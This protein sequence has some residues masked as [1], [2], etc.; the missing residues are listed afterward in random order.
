M[1]FLLTS[2]SSGVNVENGNDP[3][4]R[5]AVK[6]IP[7]GP[8]PDYTAFKPGTELQGLVPQLEATARLRSAA[9]HEA[10]A[11]RS[12]VDAAKASRRPRITPTGTATLSDETSLTIGIAATQTL[13]D[14]GRTLARIT[15]AQ[16]RITEAVLR[17]WTERTEMVR[18]GLHAFIEYSRLT[19]KLAME[20]ELSKNLDDLSVLID[21]RLEGGVAN[22]SETLK[23]Q[24]ALQQVNR[25][26]LSSESGIRMAAAELISLLPEGTPIPKAARV[27]T[28]LSSCNRQWPMTETPNEALAR[29]NAE[30]KKSNEESLRAR[31]LPKIVMAAGATLTGAAAPGVGVQIDATDVIGPGARDTIEAARAQT[32]AALVNYYSQRVTS[33]RKLDE[34]NAE[35]SVLISEEEAMRALIGVNEANF[36]LYLEQVEAGTI[37]IADG[38]SLLQEDARARIQLTD[39]QAAIIAN[40][41][42]MNAERGY[43]TSVGID[44]DE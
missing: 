16:L 4:S 33:E 21:S 38:I 43:L 36:D 25:E 10:R 14:G 29:L 19:E 35:Y 40:C 27:E 13:W 18:A 20:T 37:Q 7:P 24:V 44:T 34:L 28:L 42:K 2:C 39:V 23:L 5:L 32:E 3:T 6:D 8:D 22:R 11:A 30:R 9:A 1:V 15:E 17:S 26:K 12:D 41:V 31:R